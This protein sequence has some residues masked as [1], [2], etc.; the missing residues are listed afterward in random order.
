MAE[1]ATRIWLLRVVDRTVK[2]VLMSA[3]VVCSKVC[4]ELQML[5][6]TI[7]PGIPKIPNINKATRHV[8]RQARLEL[9]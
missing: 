1:C 3:V 8:R 2:W 6:P 7:A 5:H 9:V 4:I